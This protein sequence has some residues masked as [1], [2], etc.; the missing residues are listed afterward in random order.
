[1]NTFKEVDSREIFERNL[2]Y[3]NISLDEFTFL[4]NDL[5][6]LINNKRESL[7]NEL[8]DKI[9]DARREQIE[10]I[11]YYYQNQ[12]TIFL[13]EATFLSLIILLE[14]EIDTYCKNF[15]IHKKLTIDYNDFRGNLFDKFKIFSSKILQSDFNFKGSLWQDI[16][17]L[18]EIRNSLV[19][20]GGLIS[21]FA[22]R[23]TIESFIGRNKLFR[24]DDERV[25]ISH[26]SCL[27]SIKIVEVFFK[28]LTDFAL[29]VFPDKHQCTD[30][31]TELF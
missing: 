31:E 7:E 3:I 20:N 4:L 17:G 19:H 5:Q 13:A 6:E 15:R 26:Q 8:L 18:Y 14:N 27:D 2:F 30:N 1:M 16:L 12:P 25:C 23:K 10:K 22:K 29:K 21:D 9:T 11:L 24:I 28:K